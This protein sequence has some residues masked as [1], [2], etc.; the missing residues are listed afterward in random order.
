M[1]RTSINKNNLAIEEIDKAIANYDSA[2]KRIKEK[3]DN[4]K[5]SD[6]IDLIDLNQEELLEAKK[7]INSITTRISNRLRELEREEE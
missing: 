6:I 4:S 5:T 1:S 7:Q 2:L 3:N